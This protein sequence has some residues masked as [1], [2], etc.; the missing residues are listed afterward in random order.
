MHRLAHHVVT[1]KRE[2]DV[3]YAARDLRPGAFLLDP[4]RGVDEVDG[5]VIMLL[6]AGGD[7]QDIRIKDD[8]L[9]GEIN[10]FAQ[11]IERS[12]ADT[13][14]VLLVGGLHVWRVNVQ[15]AE[16]EYYRSQVTEDDMQL[17]TYRVNQNFLQTYRNSTDPS[18]CRRYLNAS[19]TVCRKMYP[20]VVNPLMKALA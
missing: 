12:L 8:V 10:L 19:Q 4:S 15:P 6:D 16:A 3:R 18:I 1:T 17:A 13:N 2:A 7:G 14:L 20:F 9:G 5:V 11:Q